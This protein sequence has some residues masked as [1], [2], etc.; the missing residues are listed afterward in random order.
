MAP[1]PVLIAYLAGS[2]RIVF[3]FKGRVG[4][5]ICRI[6]TEF[7]LWVSSGAIKATYKQ[8]RNISTKTHPNKVVVRHGMLNMC[9]LHKIV[10][11]LVPIVM[12]IFCC[13]ACHFNVSMLVLM[14]PRQLP[15]FPALEG[16]TSKNRTVGPSINSY[17]FFGHWNY[18]LWTALYM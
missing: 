9:F 7:I 16:L 3:Y 10:V 5:C 15:S 14:L 6:S 11:R 18:A 2:C 12:N 1:V 8:F 17:S 4:N 13:I